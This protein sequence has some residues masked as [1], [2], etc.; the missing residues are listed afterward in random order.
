MAA[1][2]TDLG[3]EGERRSG[4]FSRP[5][6]WTKMKEGAKDIICFHG[7]DDHLIPVEEARYIAK[8]M[9][10]ENFEYHEFSG[11]SHFFTPWQGIL[12]V[13]DEMMQVPS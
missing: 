9:E 10:G 1:A 7:T 3:D 5:W 12:D 13:M 2:H 6:N 11:M 8:Q 4:Y